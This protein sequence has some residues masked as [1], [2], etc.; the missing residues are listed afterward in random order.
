MPKRKGPPKLTLL[1]GGT[2]DGKTTTQQRE[3]P[4]P[5]AERPLPRS[6]VVREAEAVE[7]FHQAFEKLREAERLVQRAAQLTQV[8]AAQ[9]RGEVDGKLYAGAFFD[10]MAAIRSAMARVSE[11]RETARRYGLQLAEEHEGE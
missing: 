7:T 5:G 6:P 3:Q 8:E 1:E 4:V 2:K 11:C 9:G 10:S